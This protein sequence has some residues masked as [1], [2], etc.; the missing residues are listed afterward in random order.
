M[1][2]RE[3][4]TPGSI[5]PEEYTD[6]LRQGGLKHHHVV[7]SALFTGQGHAGRLLTQYQ[8]TEWAVWT[9]D[10]YGTPKLHDMTGD[11]MHARQLFTEQ[12][13][14]AVSPMQLTDVRV[15]VLTAAL[16]LLVNDTSTPDNTFNTAV[17][18]LDDLKEYRD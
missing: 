4:W 15:G 6:V 3:Y 17:S 11:E 12:T 7:V 18:M 8:G 16:Q 13:T 1:G 2:P 5:L 9:V 14:G 10:V